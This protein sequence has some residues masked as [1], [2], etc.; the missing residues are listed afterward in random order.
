MVRCDELAQ[1]PAGVVPDQRDVLELE[2]G[3]EVGDQRGEP[4]RRAVCALVER[5]LVRSEQPVRR[6]HA[7][8]RGET[9]RDLAP[10]LAV[11]E[12]AVDEQDRL[13]G[14]LLAV[15]DSAL[16]QLNLLHFFLPFAIWGMTRRACTRK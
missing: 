5:D 7:E 2:R 11:G 13:S 10:Q 8:V 14:A 12:Q 3:H 6:D 15:A 4:Q 9:R 16:G 1:R